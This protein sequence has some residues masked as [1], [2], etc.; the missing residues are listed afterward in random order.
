ALVK[1]YATK[2]TRSEIMQIVDIFRAKIVDVGHDS[3][4][5]EI[6]GD[7]S[8]VDSFLDL[9]RSFGIKE[10]ARTGVTAMNRGASGEVKI[11]NG[12]K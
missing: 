12:V 8:K 9:I 3:L 5:V 7:S 2:S 1:I 4:L 10:L 11:S 6:T